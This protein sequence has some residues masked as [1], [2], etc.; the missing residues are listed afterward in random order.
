MSRKI[1]SNC[2]EFVS[3]AFWSSEK[4]DKSCDI[5]NESIYKKTVIDRD[6]DLMIAAG[7]VAGKCLSSEIKGYNIDTL[8]M[9]ASNPVLS[10]IV[11]NYEYLGKENIHAIIEKDKFYNEINLFYKIY[12]FKRLGIVYIDK[13]NEKIYAAIEEARNIERDKGIKLIEEKISG[14]ITSA[15]YLRDALVEKYKI[16]SEK[17]V[18]A[19]Y[20]TD[21]LD[22]TEENIVFLNKIIPIF[23]E[24]KIATWSQTPRSWM[25]KYGV[26]MSLDGADP[27][28]IV[29]FEAKAIE[30]ILSGKKPGEINQVFIN[31]KKNS[32]TL[33]L[34]TAQKIQLDLSFDVMAS[35]NVYGEN[36]SCI[37]DD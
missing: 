20:M 21:H 15:D 10:G 9:T 7:T 37:E 26:L 22:E 3:D 13:E 28:D 34:D 33:N 12:N 8:V 24:Q 1:K 30:Q 4:A 18:D 2:L 35:A 27:V 17:K 19:I 11:N 36:I 32:V 23:K 16:L 29:M 5:N 6:V 31:P 25:V 14:D